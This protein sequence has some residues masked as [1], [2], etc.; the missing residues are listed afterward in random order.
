MSRKHFACGTIFPWE[1]VS[2]KAQE[3]IIFSD[4]ITS[5]KILYFRSRKCNGKGRLFRHLFRSIVLHEK[6]PFV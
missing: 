6:S 3:K 2:E 4:V 5:R 1:K